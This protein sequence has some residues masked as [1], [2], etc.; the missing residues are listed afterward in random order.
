MGFEPS[1]WNKVNIH[2]GGTYGDKAAA[3]QR[4]AECAP[5]PHMMPGGQVRLHVMR[6]LSSKRDEFADQGGGVTN[7]CSVGDATGWRTVVLVRL[8]SGLSIA[9]QA[10]RRRAGMIWFT[11]R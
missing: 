5:P 11:S 8:G 2:I 10:G 1:H 7:L 4:F 9:C 6:P 3:M